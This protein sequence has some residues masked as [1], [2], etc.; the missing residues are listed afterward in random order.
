M[1]ALIYKILG[2]LVICVSA[3][4]LYAGYELKNPFIAAFGFGGIIIGTFIL[5]FGLSQ[6]NR[7]TRD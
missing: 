2:V 5:L 4:N 3:Y 7:K 6:K 1:R